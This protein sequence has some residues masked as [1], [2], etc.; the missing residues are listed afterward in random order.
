MS[1]RVTNIDLRFTTHHLQRTIANL[2]QSP[3]V[4]YK[5]LTRF[6]LKKSLFAAMMLAAVVS[7]I[8]VHAQEGTEASQLSFSNLQAQANGLVERGELVKAMPL[9]KELISRVEMAADT[10]AETVKLDFPIFLVGTGYIQI[11]IQTGNKSDLQESLTWYDKL[12]KDFPRSPKIKDASLKRID[13][14]RA[15]GESKEATDL[16]IKILSG[17]YNFN[18]AF[19]ERVK[20]LRD[21]VTTFYSTGDLKNG[22]PYF[23]QLLEEARELEDRALAAAAS[24]E[25]L[26]AEKRFDEAMRLVPNLAQE[27]DVR[28][29][30]RL[31]VAL[32]QASD[33][34][35]EL[36]R[37]ND[38]AILL[39]LIKTTDIMIEFNEAKLSTAQARLEQRVAFGSN[40]EALDKLN[41]EIKK[42]ETNLESLRK[43]P[44]LRNELLVRRARNYT[45]TGRRYEAFWMFN[46]LML[47][48]P[49]DERSEFY[50]YASFANARQIGK[51]STVLELGRKYRQKYPKGDYYSDITGVLVTELNNRGEYE[52]FAEV[53]VDFLNTHPVDPISANLL[54]QWGGYK[55][56]EE[57][58]K[59]VIAQCS[60]WLS[61][62]NRSSFEDGLHYWKG[63]AELQTSQFQRA[64]D[65]FDEV[66]VKFPTS[67][68]A[69]DALL[70][71]GA[72]QFYAQAFEDARDTLL[73]YVDKYP[74]GSGL[75][76]AYFFLGEVQ[77]LAE[78]L[79][80]ALD[81]FTKAD[82]ITIQQDVHD[83]VAFK[84]GSIYEIQEQYAKMAGHF[85]A[86]I[87]TYGEAG[88]LT[89]AIFELGRSYEFNLEVTKMLG[90][91]NENIRKYITSADNSGVDTL[92]EEYAEKY[93]TN[94]TMLIRTIQFIN[95]LETDMEFRT[96]VVT[97]R[98]FLFEQFYNNPTLEQSLYNKL[99]RHPGFTPALLDDLSPIAELTDVYRREGGQFPA[100]SPEDFFREL[101]AE[102]G[103]SQNR[104]A[105]ARALMGLYR[106]DIE[107]SPQIP[108][109]EALVQSSTPRVILYI[110]DYER[111][112]RRDFAI[113]AW[114][115]ILVEYP[116]NDAAI[117]S[118]M[119]LADVS[120]DGGKNSDALNYLEAIVTQ[121]PGSPKVPAVIL[122]QGE[123]LTKMNRGA[124]AR[125]KYQYILRVPDWR[126]ILHAT[127]LF[128]IGE[129]YMAEDAF[130]E[131]HGFFE[132]TFL[133]YSQFSEL[134][135][136]AYLQD[137]N[138]LIGMG[139]A[140]SAKTTLQEAVELLSEV[141]PEETMAAIKSKLNQ[142][143]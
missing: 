121:F 71:K 113:G 29:R 141:A 58:F 14:L 111:N 123:L 18:L 37:I 67:I 49:D 86:Y 10:E 132:R 117:V 11:Y 20:M 9:L 34:V 105:E 135:A 16:M 53:V 51:M 13:V 8:A 95:Q 94:E 137:A 142:L 62:H 1:K 42:L 66:L 126:G 45:Q 138:A 116:L 41:Q 83:S 6:T 91:Y 19:K 56:S 5:M 74:N 85:E 79:P 114:N 76:Q 122:R 54:A 64:I 109:D 59:D 21:L 48:N 125:E 78:N 129:S 128:Q 52:E 120:A 46:D 102:H 103:K 33:A 143:P 31:N 32:L 44:T 72:A 4:Y 2:L 90:L 99:R 110:A 92:I 12:E 118:Y 107:L 69:E 106:L 3:P 35:V 68:Y 115:H 124:E 60:S 57:A 84:I 55:F 25:T 61:M 43:L 47:E 130:A 77:L 50:L 40:Q 28:Y 73:V 24:F 87:S 75:D 112:K 22:L 38:A 134:A 108:F 131:A 119:R 17:G 26:A 89:D 96:K 98:G 81:Y 36:G 136:K 139:N 101:L 63:L 65:S 82:A 70:R 100:Q 104:T 88:R 7:P 39:N 140:A 93:T 27:S 30:P 127:A 97:D 15:L 80:V 133:G 23:T